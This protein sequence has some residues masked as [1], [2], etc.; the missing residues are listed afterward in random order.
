MDVFWIL[1]GTALWWLAI[2][3][4]KDITQTVMTYRLKIATAERDAKKYELEIARIGNE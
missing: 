3:G 2:Y 4:A 1:A